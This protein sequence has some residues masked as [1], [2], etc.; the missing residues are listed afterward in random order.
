MLNNLQL[1]RRDVRLLRWV[2]Q[3]GYQ[4]AVPELEIV[5]ET[6]SPRAGCGWLRKVRG[7]PRGRLSC[8]RLGHTSCHVDAF[9]SN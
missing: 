8:G 6:L 4:R 1:S 3:C 9:G 5:G 7:S 2:G